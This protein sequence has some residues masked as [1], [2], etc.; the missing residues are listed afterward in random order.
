MYTDYQT[1]GSHFIASQE[2]NLAVRNTVC[3]E[4]N[5]TEEAKTRDGIVQIVQVKSQ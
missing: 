5:E 3:H 2:L 4:K 1:C